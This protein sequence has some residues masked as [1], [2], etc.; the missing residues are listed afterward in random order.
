Y[1]PGED[2]VR[3]ASYVFDCCARG[4][5]PRVTSGRQPRD[6]VFVDDVVEL[7]WLAVDCPAAR[8]RILHAG[9]GRHQTV[10]DL[11][12]TAVAVAGGQVVPEYGTEPPRADEPAVWLADLTDT[13]ALTG[14]RP[15]TD[16]RTGLERMWAGRFTRA[17]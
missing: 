4:E 9:G 10:R 12:E 15:R 3:L 2:P 5:A 8:G 17:A 13:T 16:L 7:I 14:W 11:V 6:W 1:G